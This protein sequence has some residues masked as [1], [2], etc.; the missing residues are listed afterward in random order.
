MGEGENVN[1]YDEDQIFSHLVFYLDTPDNA[2]LNGLAESSPPS[3]AGD[4][5]VTITPVVCAEPV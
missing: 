5:W 1:A 3:A 2:K 4:R